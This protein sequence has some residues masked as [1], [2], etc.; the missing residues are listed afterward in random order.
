MD[1]F[2]ARP[3]HSRVASPD[4][5]PGGMEESCS[6]QDWEGLPGRQPG[7]LAA[8]PPGGLV[9]AADLLGDQDAEDF[10]GVPA[11]RPR[12][13]QHLGCRVAQVGQPHPLEH[14]EEFLG[15]VRRRARC[16]GAGRPRTS[17]CCRR[18]G[19]WSA[20]RPNVAQALVPGWME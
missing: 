4:W 2:S 12:G 5:V 16:G 7:G 8:H 14:R 3:T 19:H 1:R 20:C 10:G 9:A 13:G 17:R 6:R 18:G 11:L 15:Q